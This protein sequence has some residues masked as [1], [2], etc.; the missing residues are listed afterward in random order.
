MGDLRD[1]QGNR[2][3]QGNTA[4]L[5]PAREA[6][7]KTEACTRRGVSLL[8]FAPKSWV[9]GDGEFFLCMW[10]FVLYKFKGRG[11]RHRLVTV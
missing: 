6:Q 2:Q 1:G 11:E 8:R 10:V 5:R 3:T 9:F 4:P 7:L